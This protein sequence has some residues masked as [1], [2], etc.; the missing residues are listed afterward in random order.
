[1]QSLFTTEELVLKYPRI[2]GI[3]TSLRHIKFGYWLSI[4]PDI[5]LQYEADILDYNQESSHA[6]YHFTYL[7]DHTS[8]LLIKNKGSKNYFYPKYK[9]VDYLICA[10]NEEEI[11]SEIVQIV[12]KITGISICFA[13]DNPNPKE[14]INFTQLQ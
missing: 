7:E 5:A 14:I 12:S 10:I 9:K 4:H 6:A 11:N 1:M 2:Y 13:L 3:A 8:C